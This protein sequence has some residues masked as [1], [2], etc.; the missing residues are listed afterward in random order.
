MRDTIELIPLCSF[1]L[2][3]FGPK[4]AQ[5]TSLIRVDVEGG[6]EQVADDLWFPN[7]A[8]VTDD[9]VLLVNETL[10][11]RVTAFDID[12]HGDLRNRRVWAKFGG[13]PAGDDIVTMITGAKPGP[14]LALIAGNHGYEYPPV[15]A[16]QK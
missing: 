4:H 3:G 11:N 8:V 16:L 10:G 9:G 12:A 15:L 13:V 6:V 14:T 7:G 5:T 2:A 1:I